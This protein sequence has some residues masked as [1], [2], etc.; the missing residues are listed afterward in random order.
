MRKLHKSWNIYHKNL[1]TAKKAP[2]I[3]VGNATGKKDR[4]RHSLFGPELVKTTT[5]CRLVSAKITSPVTLYLGTLPGLHIYPITQKF[6]LYLIKNSH[7]NK[8]RELF[9][10]FWNF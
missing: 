6:L 8:K 4:G 9:Q 2:Y 10:I 1:E 5:D 3:P 7:S